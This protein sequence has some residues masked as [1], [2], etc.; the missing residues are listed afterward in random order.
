[1][2]IWAITDGVEKEAYLVDGAAY[3][4][5]PK[6]SNIRATARQ[7][8]DIRD[9]ALFLIS[10]PGWGIRMNPGAGIIYRGINIYLD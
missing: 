3:L 10:N 6:S 7:F 1:M 8:T 9:A 5:F 2:R 4:C